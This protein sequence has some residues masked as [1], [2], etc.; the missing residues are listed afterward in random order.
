MDLTI[1]QLFR[2]KKILPVP[3]IPEWKKFP[4][5]TT[6]LLGDRRR[7]SALSVFIIRYSEP[8]VDLRIWY[9]STFSSPI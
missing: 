9:S 3:T 2:L 5:K 4:L 7:S 6:P 8:K 1:L